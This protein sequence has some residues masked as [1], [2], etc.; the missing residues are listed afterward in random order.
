MRLPDAS[1]TPDSRG[2]LLSVGNPRSLEVGARVCIPE[3][4]SRGSLYPPLTLIFTSGPFAHNAGSPVL[5]E[6][7][8]A[9]VIPQHSK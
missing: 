1:L 7:S 6:K 5:V 4:M 9:R 8:D 3:A 2:C